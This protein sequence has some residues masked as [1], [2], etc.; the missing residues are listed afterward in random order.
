MISII[1][2]THN[3]KYLK[4]AYK[5]LKSQTFKD[6]EWIIVPNNGAKVD[7]KDDKIKIIPFE[8][9]T[10][11]IGEIKKFAFSQGSGDIIN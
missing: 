9:K 1:T 5:S 6:W 4:E 7:L 8:K 3:P 2:P 10:D 11:K